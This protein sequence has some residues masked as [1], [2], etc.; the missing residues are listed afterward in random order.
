MTVNY[1]FRADPLS[2][3]SLTL[4]F[5]D[6]ESAAAF[7]EKNGEYKYITYI[8]MTPLCNSTV[9]CHLTQF[10]PTRALLTL[11]TWT[12]IVLYLIFLLIH[13]FQAC[14]RHL[15][16]QQLYIDFVLSL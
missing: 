4:D 12:L 16:N 13:P 14:F 15:D 9:C 11:Y 2:N 5:P 8:S 10:D 3:I 7:C 6:P 1:S